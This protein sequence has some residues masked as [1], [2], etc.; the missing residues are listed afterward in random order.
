MGQPGRGSRRRAVGVQ[1]EGSPGSWRWGCRAAPAHTRA[2][3]T[4]SSKRRRR[5][6]VPG[7]AGDRKGEEPGRGLLG[8]LGWRRA[9]CPPSDWPLCPGFLCGQALKTVGV[10]FEWK[11]SRLSGWEEFMGVSR[12]ACGGG[13]G[14]CYLLRG[15][16]YACAV[17]GVTI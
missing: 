10:R 5:P 14:V 16:W 8:K 2:P 1:G 6:G 7:W 15:V 12:A 13:V 4:A 3:H 11:Q 17:L 9:S